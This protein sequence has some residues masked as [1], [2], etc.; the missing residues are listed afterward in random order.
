MVYSSH[1]LNREYG[2]SSFADLMGANGWETVSALALIGRELWL[3][4]MP[5][6]LPSN[7]ILLSLSQKDLALLE[8]DLESVDL[9]LRRQLEARNRQIEHV[10]FP[11]S[12]F[13]SV[14][15]N[16]ES[17]RQVEVGLIGRE[18]MTGVALLMGADRTPN[19][20]YIQLAGKGRRVKAARF[21]RAIGES[22]GLRRSCLKFAHTLVMQ[23][24][25]TAAAN[26][27]N[28]LEERLARWLLMAHDRADGDDLTLTHEFLG[29]ML[30]TQRPGVTITMN[31]LERRGF[32]RTRRGV[33]SII[34]RASLEKCAG[35]A[36]G[37][38]EAELKRLFR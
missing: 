17:N 22:A 36:Y 24:T 15:A 25:H 26:A 10:Y 34:D 19:E 5:D 18:G 11:D 35:G 38:P 31:E 30:G 14:V 4:Q 2:R 1:G 32:I 16:G 6:N 12:G 33:I 21:V 20:T 9:P 13:A 37:A 3:N 23:A 27:R 7:R 29:F 28:K 8:P